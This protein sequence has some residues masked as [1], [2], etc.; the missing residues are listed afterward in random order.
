M[1][2]YNSLNLL[3]QCLNANRISYTLIDGLAVVVW[4][5]PRLTRDI[6]VK[7]L[8]ERDEAERL[9]SAIRT[10]YEPFGDNPLE[11]L[12]KNGILF[13]HDKQN[14]RIDFHLSDT[15]FDRQVI[16]RAK[17]IEIKPGIMVRICTAEDLIIYK[18]LSMRILDARDAEG[19]INYQGDTLDDNYIIHWLKQFEQALDD[20]TLVNNYKR[21]RSLQDNF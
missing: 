4:G 14:I 11:M 19:I 6:D 9:L 17:D 3:H 16:E 7:V 15:L 21:M 10:E 20:S 12:K 8:L 18:M 1:K 2:I 13:A 5:E